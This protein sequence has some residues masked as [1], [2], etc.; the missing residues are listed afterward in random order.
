MKDNTDQVW[1]DLFLFNMSKVKDTNR[2]YGG[3]SLRES[4][5]STEYLGELDIKI[6]V[7]VL[8]SSKLS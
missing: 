1:V 6:V 8:S 2:A 4:N 7:M 5:G 3:R